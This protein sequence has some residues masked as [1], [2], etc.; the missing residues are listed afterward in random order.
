MI[1]AYHLRRIRFLFSLEL[2]VFN[3]FQKKKQESTNL[4]TGVK[5]DGRRDVV[6]GVT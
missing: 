5:I 2:K 1:G 4:S 3:I 6:S